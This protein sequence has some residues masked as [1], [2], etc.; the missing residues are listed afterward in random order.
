MSLLQ[1]AKVFWIVFGFCN[2]VFL[3]QYYLIFDSQLPGVFAL[4]CNDLSIVLIALLVPTYGIGSE[5][6]R[7]PSA[8][9]VLIVFFNSLTG[10]IALLVLTYGSDNL[11]SPSGDQEHIPVGRS[12]ICKSSLK[13]PIP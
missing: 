5:N 10:L 9:Q 8:D 3:Q 13:S 11:R 6:L 4:S 12:D 7:S 1:A 2:W